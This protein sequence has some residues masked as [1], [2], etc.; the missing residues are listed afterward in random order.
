MDRNAENRLWKVS[1]RSKK[2]QHHVEA[3]NVKEDD[4]KLIFT[5]AQGNLTGSFYLAE[6]QG[7]SA[8]P[9]PLPSQLTVKFVGPA[10]PPETKA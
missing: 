8:E 1:V 3:A 9:A 6:V 5:D 10:E 4:G 7:Y 2:D